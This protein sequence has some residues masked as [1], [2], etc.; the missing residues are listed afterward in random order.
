MNVDRAI[1][2]WEGEGG[3][4]PQ[5]QSSRD[6]HGERFKALTL[7]QILVPIDFS[8]ESLKTLRYAKRVAERFKAKLHLVHVV[9]P[10]PQLPP[11][12]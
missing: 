10:P 5:V 3:A 7:R 4:I 11:R 9:T 8:P 1:A 6:R 12:P 2:R